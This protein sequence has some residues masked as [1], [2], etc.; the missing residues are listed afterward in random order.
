VAAPV[1]MFSIGQSGLQ[2]TKASL[3]TTSHNIANANTEGFSRQSVDQAAGPAIPSGRMTF[4]TGVR[5]KDIK[6]VNDEYLEKRLHTENK[7]FGNVEEKDIYLQQ[8]E[9]IFNEA[10]NDG[11]NRLATKFFNE[12]RKLSSDP[13]NEAIRA[14]VREASRQLVGDINRMDRSLKDVQANIDTKIEGYVRE[15]NGMAKEIRDLNLLIERSE[16]EG[17]SAADLQDKRDLALKKLGAMTDISVSK[18]KSNKVIVTMNNHIALV[19]GNQL[20]KLEVLRTPPDPESGKKEGR[21]DI[22]VNEPVP[23]KITDLIRTGRLGGLLEVRDRDVTNAQTKIDD[24]AYSLSKGVN[25]IHA[26]GY[27]RDGQSG[28]MFFRNLEGKDHAAERLDLSEDVK[29]DINAIAAAREPNAPSDNRIAIAISGLADL[30][31]ETGEDASILDK[32]N[33]MV[34]EVAVKT[35][36]N[37]RA[38]VFQ[39]DVL[40]QLENFREAQSGV[41]L[42]EETAN[43]I[44][45]QHAYAANAKV[46]QVADEMMQTVLNA[47]K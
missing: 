33:A 14:S 4:G 10:N 40:S 43:L 41:S 3:S 29:Q 19:N 25:E 27:G 47:F 44:R 20:T 21:L 11:L 46:M 22:F 24:V 26:Q 9:Q 12:F 32:Y 13:S 30:K 36:S 37:K 38:L 17:S 45:F 16:M 15:V 23:A 7:N 18:D 1:N 42:D 6:R 2:A 39:K 35:G 28:R 34:S 31:D 8:T 5:M